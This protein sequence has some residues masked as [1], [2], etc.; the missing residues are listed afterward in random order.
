MQGK[1]FEKNMRGKDMNQVNI[2]QENMVLKDDM[3]VPTNLL[4]SGS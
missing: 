1:Y 4:G 3:Q 2:L